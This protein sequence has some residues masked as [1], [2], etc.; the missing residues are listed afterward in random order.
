M[1]KFK[2]WLYGLGIG[3]GLMYFLDPQQGDRRKALVRDQMMRFRD[4]SKGAI[5]VGVRDL[6]NR[7]RG[8]L[9]EGMAIVSNEGTPDYVMEER[10]RSRLGFLTRHPGAVQVS[11]RNGEVVIDGDIL[12]NESES[13]VAGLQRLRGVKNIQNNLR[14]HQEAG[15]ISTLQGEGWMPGDTRGSMQWTPAARLLAGGGAAYLLLYGLFRGG[16]I[17]TMAKVG[18]LILGARAFTNMDYK[19]MTGQQSDFE[20]VR[21]RKSINIDAPVEEVYG[22]WSNFE[23]FSRFMNNIEEIHDMGDGRSHWVVKGPAGSKV[24]FEAQ[25]TQNVPNE[26]VAWETTPD[27]MVKHRGQV[28]FKE[29]KQGQGTTVNVN[30]AYTPPAGVAGHA[31]AKLFG[32]DPKSEMDDDLARMKTLLE[33]G[34]TSAG[35]QRVRRDDVMPVTGQSGKEE[36]TSDTTR[37]LDESTLGGSVIGATDDADDILP[38]TGH[39]GM[40]AD[41]ETGMTDF[42]EE[43]GAL[44]EIDA[45]MIED[46]EPGGTG[47]SR[48]RRDND[49][50]GGI[51]GGPLN[52]SEF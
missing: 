32:K 7:T 46:D 18:G 10:L 6:R 25:M 27:S 30:M 16:F 40:E 11:V 9:A 52:T 43:S 28:R 41:V 14:V 24:E 8:L 19:T 22:L 4:E 49:N 21:V 50:M 44:D 33:Q 20:A 29:N 35:G 51:G 34:K 37:D 2:A 17:G 3:A 26:V 45:G 13:F 47:E 39:S 42:D 31:V 1:G 15:N 48:S 5:D 36:V 12:E 38:V 23:N